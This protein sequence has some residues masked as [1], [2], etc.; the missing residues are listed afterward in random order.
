MNQAWMADDGHWGARH[1]YKSNNTTLVSLT[2]MIR[3]QHQ[4]YSN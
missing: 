4:G 3:F 1:S 2:L